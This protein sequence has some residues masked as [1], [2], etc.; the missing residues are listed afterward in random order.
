MKRGST[1][2][3]RMMTRWTPGAKERNACCYNTRRSLDRLSSNQNEITQ[4]VDGWRD[5]LKFLVRQLSC[6]AQP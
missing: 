1:R 3:G 4:S 5:R 2:M 6:R